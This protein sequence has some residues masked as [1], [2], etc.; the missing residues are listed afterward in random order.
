[1]ICTWPEIAPILYISPFLLL[2]AHGVWY[3]ASACTINCCVQQRENMNPF[4]CFS[5]DRSQLMPGW[6]HFHLI[7][8]GFSTA[9]GRYSQCTSVCSLL[10]SRLMYENVLILFTVFSWE[11]GGFWKVALFKVRRCFLL[12]KGLLQRKVDIFWS[13]ISN[14]FVYFSCMR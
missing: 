3:V 7:C 10:Q 5:C 14:I 1:M 9:L 8:D 6:D 11:D 12:W 13:Q 2:L 4:L